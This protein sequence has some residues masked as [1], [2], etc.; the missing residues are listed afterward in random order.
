MSAAPNQNTVHPPDTMKKLMI[1]GAAGGQL[2]FIN[3]A[4]ARGYYTIV[5]SPQGDYPG[6]DIADKAYYFDTRD[7]EHI[8]EA[9]RAE[10]IDAITTDQTDVSVPTVAYVA[11]HMNLPGIGEDLA[12]QFTDKYE[13]RKKARE[14]GIAVPDF[15]KAANLDDALRAGGELGYPLIIKPLDSSG[16]RGVFKLANAADM[17]RLFPQ[18]LAFSGQGAVILEQFING[19]EFVADGFAMGGKYRTLDICIKEHFSGSGRFIANMCMFFSTA[20]NL[21]DDLREVEATDTRLMQGMGLP[22]G[23]THSEYIRSDDDGRVYLVEC[24]AR[25]GGV[26]ISSHLTRYACGFD[27]NTALID[28]LME[29]T[30][31]FP[32]ASELKGDISAWRCFALPEGVIRQ[33]SGKDELLKIPA[34]RDVF[35]DGLQPG[36]QV[37]KL[38]DDGQKLGPIIYCGKTESELREAMAQSA[39][40]LHIE[41]ATASGPAN[42]IW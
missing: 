7:K 22:F 33:C 31:R 4:K 21:P 26:F 2:P 18:S 42:I 9:A 3:I 40:T 16:S 37:H 24:A 11:K 35:L 41:V 6:F 23:I 36:T 10:N 8:L 29:G 27:T 12:L 32:E 39:R 5:V 38:E 20:A 1:L 15:R 28:F 25:G 17:R 30:E 34:V 14:L 19:R 13:M